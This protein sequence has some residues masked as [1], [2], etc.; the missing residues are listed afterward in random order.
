MKGLDCEKKDP[1][2]KPRDQSALILCVLWIHQRRRRELVQLSSDAG[3][4]WILETRAFSG[5]GHEGR[6][7]MYLEERRNERRRR[8]SE[9]LGSSRS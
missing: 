3:E 2:V 1:H 9:S 4:D 7:M 8:R 6:C 5:E